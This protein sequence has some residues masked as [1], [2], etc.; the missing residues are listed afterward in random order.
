MCTAQILSYF[1]SQLAFQQRGDVSTLRNS[2]VIFR[3]QIFFFNSFSLIGFYWCIRIE[4]ALNSLCVTSNRS[5]TFA[6][7]N[8]SETMHVFTEKYAYIPTYTQHRN[9]CASR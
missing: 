9:V 6:S 2:L 7:Y 8:R 5:G 4:A 1:P 3:K